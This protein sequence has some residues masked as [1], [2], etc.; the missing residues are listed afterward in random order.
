MTPRL[1]PPRRATIALYHEAG[2]KQGSCPDQESRSN[3][4]G[5]KKAAEQLELEGFTAMLHPPVSLSTQAVALR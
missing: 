4:G 2:I 5:I 3:L 1:H